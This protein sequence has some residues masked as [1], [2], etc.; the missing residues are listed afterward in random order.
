MKALLKKA[1]KDQ[2]HQAALAAAAAAAHAQAATAAQ[3][4]MS[5]SAQIIGKIIYYFFKYPVAIRTA[6]RN[7]CTDLE[8]LNKILDMIG[9]LFLVSSL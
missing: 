2:D 1:M 8:G 9:L 3:N 4:Q 5:K 7:C 6:C